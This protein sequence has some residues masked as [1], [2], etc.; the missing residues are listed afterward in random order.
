MS[1]SIIPF[2]PG[3]T[4]PKPQIPTAD[5]SVA[6]QRAWETAKDFESFFISRTLDS[7]FAGVKTDGPFGGGQGES[8]F[9]GLLNEEYGKIMGGAGGIGIADAVYREMIRLQEGNGNANA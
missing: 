5:D 4:I 2:V 8:M 3:Q 7:M 6:R 1:M 9:R